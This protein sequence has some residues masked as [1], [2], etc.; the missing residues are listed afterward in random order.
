MASLQ[1]SI[2]TQSMQAGEQQK[3]LMFGALSNLQAIDFEAW[4]K[5]KMSE[6]G[7]MDLLGKLLGQ[8]GE[9]GACALGKKL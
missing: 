3:G 7:F 4:L 9:V 5:K 2:M 8:A 6:P 1:N